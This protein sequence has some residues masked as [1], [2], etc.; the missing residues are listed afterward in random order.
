MLGVAPLEPALAALEEVGRQEGPGRITTALV[1]QLG[2]LTVVVGL[3]GAEVPS[4]W[5]KSEWHTKQRPRSTITESQNTARRSDSEQSP[6]GCTPVDG[7]PVPL[8]QAASTVPHT[9]A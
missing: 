7:A 5:P 2:E 1:A 8:E 9:S 4:A 6:R 3:A